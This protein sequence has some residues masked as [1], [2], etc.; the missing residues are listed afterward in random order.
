MSGWPG[1]VGHNWGS[2]HAESWVWLHADG[3]GEQPG[4]WLE[5]VLA[6]V[7]AGRALLPWTAFG[8]LSLDGERLPARRARP[9]GCGRRGP[10]RLTA[11][12]TAPGDAA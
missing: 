4:D 9:G 1:T 6:R 11:T 10:A 5:L 7:R 2:E 12:I 3:F 8:A